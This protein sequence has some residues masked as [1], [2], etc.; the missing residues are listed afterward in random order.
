MDAE[1]KYTAQCEKGFLK[2]VQFSRRRRALVDQLSA[3]EFRPLCNTSQ[4]SAVRA[5]HAGHVKWII[6]GWFIDDEA[7][8]RTAAFLANYV[9]FLAHGLPH[10]IYLSHRC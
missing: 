8:F 9:E 1:S 6:Y 7:D 4:F 5:T 3:V 10:S 2:R